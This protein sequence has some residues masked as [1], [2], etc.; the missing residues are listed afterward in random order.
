[1]PCEGEVWGGRIPEMLARERQRVCVL[2]SLTTGRRENPAPW[3]D[4]IELI[5]NG[6][7][8]QYSAG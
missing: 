6:V 3:L 7:D 2:D 4:R 5:E 1:M 8:E